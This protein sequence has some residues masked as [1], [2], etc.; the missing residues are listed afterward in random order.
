MGT[1]DF[2][3]L[4]YWLIPGDCRTAMSCVPDG[5][6][7]CCVTSPPYY[8]LRN[9]GVDGQIGNERSP[10]EYV[11]SL[12]EV[13]RE[14]KRVLR[15]DGTLW[16]NI[17]DCYWSSPNGD[18]GSAGEL[19]FGGVKRKDKIGI[20]WMLA[21]ALRA[22]G[23]YLRQDII[24]S[25]ANAQPESV[26]DRCVCSHEYVFVLSKQEKYYYDHEAVQEPAGFDPGRTSLAQAG[27]R[28]D[29]LFDD[30]PE[31]DGLTPD[32]AHCELGRPIRMGG[33]KYGDSDDPHYATRSGKPW[34]PK[35]K[36]MAG[37]EK[38]IVRNRRDVWTIATTKAVDVA[39]FAT[40]PR[41]LVEP[42]VLAGSRPGGTV[43]DPFNGSG[44]TGLVALGL[45]RKYIGVELNPEYVALTES[46][47]RSD[48][49]VLQES[50]F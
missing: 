2:C 33:S 16:V 19:A 30:L 18:D 8:N 26:T 25:K 41:A 6:V 43:L 44:T 1:T 7:D 35:V 34:R 9:Y 29:G 12:V 49:D 50:I 11:G 42:C 21:F 14:V 36:T 37:G 31:F 27:G 3:D 46:R 20:P 10:G 48:P 38:V 4:G 24:W 40:Y 23:W 39:H 17:G 15:D 5:S 22:D 45:G 32:G 47:L 28:E 13:F